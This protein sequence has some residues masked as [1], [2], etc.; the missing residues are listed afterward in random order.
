[1]KEDVRIQEILESESNKE[2]ASDKQNW[3]D[4]LVKNDKDEYII[5][6]VQQSSEI[7]YFHR[8]L[9]A[10]SKLVT[11][12][13]KGGMDYGVIKRI[14]SINIVYFDLGQGDDY[15]YRGKNE[16]KGIHDGDFLKLSKKQRDAYVRTDISQI[17]PEYYIIKVNNFDDVAKDTLDEWI[18]F[19]K[20]SEVKDEFRA[21]EIQKA[22]EELDIMK[23]T[24]NERRSFE[25]YMK[26]WRI[27]R[28]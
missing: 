1:M 24:E 8:M 2:D 18:Y 16:F 9:Y 12:Q 23:L 25:A 4:L 3:V 10:T 7:D 5:I 6:E 13:I 14:I 19:F 27:D 26:D 22:K 11:E 17:F 15:V 20:N 21:K 28:S